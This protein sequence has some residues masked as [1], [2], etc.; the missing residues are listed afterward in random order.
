MLQSVVDLQM[1]SKFIPLSKLVVTKL[2]GI[3]DPRH[4]V[5]SV[6]PQTSLGGVEISAGPTS[7]A[8]FLLDH[9]R[10]HS[11]KLVRL[12]FLLLY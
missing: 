11:S 4:V 2:A 8:I 9:Q 3:V 10:L 5:L 6:V 1:L 12:I 7:P